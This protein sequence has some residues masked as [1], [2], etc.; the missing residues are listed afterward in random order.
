M[1]YNRGNVVGETE[2]GRIWGSD[3]TVQGE[4]KQRTEEAD[5]GT[6]QTVSEESSVKGK[7][8]IR[9]VSCPQFTW[10]TALFCATVFRGN[11]LF[12]CG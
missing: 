1:V 4:N 11:L 2:A 7:D 5:A 9:T 6:A 3:E 8:R 10:R 12:R